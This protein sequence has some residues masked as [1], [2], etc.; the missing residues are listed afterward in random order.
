VPEP[1]QQ[2]YADDPSI[3]PEERLLR[4]VPHW[5]FVNDRNLARQR[6]S[7]A[8]FED[9]PNGSPMSVH[10]ESVLVGLGLRI[11]SVLAGHPHFALASISAAVAR[12]NGQGICRR[13]EPRD[14]A[15]AEV[16]GPKSG[17]VRRRFAKLAEWVIPP[18]S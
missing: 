14:P 10:L 13:P 7:S 3:P 9:H 16:F 1:S 12:A 11:D 4:R 15:H 6:P 5:H 17:S 8:A 18:P 2:Q